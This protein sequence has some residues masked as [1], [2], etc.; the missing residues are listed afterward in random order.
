MPQLTEQQKQNIISRLGQQRSQEEPRIRALKTGVGIERFTDPNPQ[1]SAPQIE[2]PGILESLFES[3]VGLPQRLASIPNIAVK[4]QAGGRILQQRISVLEKGGV[5]RQDALNQVRQ[6]FLSGQLPELSA[7][8]PTEEELGGILDLGALAFPAGKLAGGLS[9]LPGARFL[10][11]APGK[12]GLRLVPKERLAVKAGRGALLGAKGVALLPEKSEAGSVEDRLRLAAEGGAIGASLA[13]VAKLLSPVG[14]VIQEEIE[15]LAQRALTAKGTQRV[16]AKFLESK[17]VNVLRA[18]KPDKII[19]EDLPALERQVG[20]L[21]KDVQSALTP[22]GRLLEQ[23]AENIALTGTVSKAAK[24]ARR[25]LAKQIGEAESFRVSADLIRNIQERSVA[26]TAGL[27]AIAKVLGTQSESEEARTIANTLAKRAIQVQNQVGELS[28][29]AARSAGLTLRQFQVPVMADRAALEGAFAELSDTVGSFIRQG[30]V[31]GVKGFSPLQR[32]INRVREGGSITGAVIRGGVDFWRLNIFPLFSAGLD[33]ASNSIATTSLLKQSVAADLYDF[34]GKGQS[35]TRTKGLIKGIFSRAALKA[36]PAIEERL[37][38]TALG[39]RIPT[40]F[41]GKDLATF[42]FPDRDSSRMIRFANQVTNIADR[43]LFVPAAAKRGIDTAFKRMGAM[44][45]LHERALQEAERQGLRGTA[46]VAFTRRFVEEAPDAVVEDAVRQGQK[47]GF[48]RSLSK[49]E[50]ELAGSGNLG[51]VIKLFISPFP[52]WQMQL[53]RFVAEHTPISPEFWSK[54]KAGKATGTDF[55]QFMDRITTGVLGVMAVDELLYD[56]MDL[57]T[58]EYI[59]EDGSRVP[60]G[61]IEPIPQ[62]IAILAALKGDGATAFNALRRA[63]TFGL[64]TEGIL[65]NVIDGLSGL[66][67]NREDIR[68]RAVAK[69]DRSL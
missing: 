61:F 4:Q 43:V 1:P 42:I 49:I 8:L 5:S 44:G 28:A 6:E 67:S 34:I 7:L 25:L 19:N 3:V 45:F 12:E 14:R 39:E 65:T 60:L 16:Q 18:R 57:K 30:R 26:V 31:F 36:T 51:T 24:P 2:Q 66:A 32:E 11:T 62:A 27:R 17:L 47:I 21:T 58:L 53:Y 23:E 38:P 55:V 63:G 54:V 69:F 29:K 13:P 52:R 9:K 33:F 40:G 64:R 68:E 56:K 20:E 15:S 22:A 46:K 41:F 48:N 59:R 10:T 37:V 50:E 35:F